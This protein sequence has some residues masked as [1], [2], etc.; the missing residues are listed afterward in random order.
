MPNEQR[1]DVQGFLTRLNG[2]SPRSRIVLEAGFLEELLRSAI[3]RR[4][5]DNR[6]SR[7]LF[8][9]ESSIGLS[10]I[11][12]YAHALG[13]IGQCELDAIKKFA[14]ARNMIAHSW[15]VDFTDAKL[16]KIAA[17]MQFIVL[18]GEGQMQDHQ[19]CFARL[20]YFGVYLS[21]EL[22]NRFSKMPGSIF[23]GGEF[24]RGVVV[25]VTSGKREIKAERMP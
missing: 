10:V 8:G 2:E 25:D 23:N 22:V 20:D 1:H 19:R 11:S 16:Q 15:S 6:T 18:K 3:I 17:S 21:E 12:K 4:L 13:L 9:E 14:K 24:A 5:A 7:E